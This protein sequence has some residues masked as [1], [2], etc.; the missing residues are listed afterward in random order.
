VVL[1]AGSSGI[2]L[3]EAI[4]HGMEADFNRKGTSIYSDK[5]GKP[6]ARPFVSIVDDATLPGARGT[7]NVDDEGNDAGRTVL[8]QDGV[9]TSYMHDQISARHYGV[10]PTGNGRRQSYRHPPLPRM[11]ATYMLPGPHHPAEIIASVKRGLYCQNF[12]NGQVNIGGGDFSFYV[13]NGFLIE[14]GKL[15]RPVKDVNVIGNGPK[16]LEKVDMVGDDLEIDEGGWTCG[17]DGQSVPVSQGL[18]TVRVSCL[19]VGGRG[20]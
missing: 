7:I 5:L 15:T 20:A 9:L 4:G 6:V 1:A 10:T 16:A 3:H 17:K 11:R 19:T 2:L 12:S 18:P 13:K 14:D 8:V